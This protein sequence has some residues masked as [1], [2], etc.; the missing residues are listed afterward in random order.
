LPNYNYEKITKLLKKENEESCEIVY[1][2]SDCDSRK[3]YISKELKEEY[4]YIIIHTTARQGIRYLYS[5]RNDKGFF[6]ISKVIFGD[7]GTYNAVLD[8]KGEYGLSSHSIGIK[9]YNENEGNELL[10][11]L[12]S[13]EFLDIIKSCIW[14]SYGIDWNL[15]KYFKKDFYKHL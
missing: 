7:S 1:S 9:V 4:P 13:E 8:L 3:T 15:F 11:Y 5:S 12:K 14:S 2:R 10:V 6:G